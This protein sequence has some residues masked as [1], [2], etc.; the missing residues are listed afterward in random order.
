[1]LV[2]KALSCEYKQYNV[3]FTAEPVRC[4]VLIKPFW[5]KRLACPGGTLGGRTGLAQLRVFKHLRHGFQC[6]VCVNA[7]E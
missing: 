4:L 6:G 2:R 1:M 7:S 3:T 5:A